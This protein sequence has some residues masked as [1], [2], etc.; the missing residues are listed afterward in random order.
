MGKH[1]FNA[2]YDNWNPNSD[3]AGSAQT[4]DSFDAS[5][6]GIVLKIGQYIAPIL[7]IEAHYVAGLSG[8]SFTHNDPSNPDSSKNNYK[9]DV[10]FNSAWGIFAKPMGFIS[11]TGKVYA[12]IGFGGID[13]DIDTIDSSFNSESSTSGFAYGLGFE[14]EVEYGVFLGAEYV[15]YLD[16]ADGSYDSFNVTLTMYIW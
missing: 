2:T 5:G 15:A 13:F 7:A 14:S 6:S 8:D 4:S 11:D 3:P 9:S 10:D 16:T 1:K 12:L